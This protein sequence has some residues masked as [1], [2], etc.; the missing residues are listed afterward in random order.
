MAFP[1]I[2]FSFSVGTMGKIYH[3]CRK[4]NLRNVY[5]CHPKMSSD[6]QGGELVGVKSTDTYDYLVVFCRLTVI[7][8][9]TPLVGR[10]QMLA[11]KYGI[12]LRT[13][14]NLHVMSFYRNPSDHE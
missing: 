7:K 3:V 9:G 14:P 5:T 8:I 11:R 12:V 4:Y 2:L 13:P 10:L 6:R 1:A